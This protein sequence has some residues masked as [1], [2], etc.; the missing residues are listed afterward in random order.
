MSPPKGLEGTRRCFLSWLP[1]CPLWEAEAEDEEEEEDVEETEEEDAAAEEEQEEEE[2]EEEVL[3][4]KNPLIFFPRE[5]RRDP[6]GASRRSGEEASRLASF[7]S[8]VFFLSFFGR[9]FALR[10]EE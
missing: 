5:R 4:V 7:L 2:E 9:L 3:P 10:G 6:D 8:C 1:S